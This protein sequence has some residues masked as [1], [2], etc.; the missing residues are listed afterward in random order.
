MRRRLRSAIWPFHR[1]SLPQLAIDAVLVAGAYFLAYRLRFDSG[2]PRRYEHLLT[3]TLP[4]AVVASLIVFTLF[5]MYAKQWRYVG[6]R[7]FVAILQA[8]IV[9]AVV[10][11]AAIAVIHPTT[12][13]S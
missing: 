12:V 4:W 13:A 9:A 1:H 10:L 8:V 6:Q 11:T 3:T 2:V 5:G 7:D